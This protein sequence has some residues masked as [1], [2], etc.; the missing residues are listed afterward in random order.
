MFFKST[1]VLNSVKQILY[2]GFTW[3]IALVFLVAGIQKLTDPEA[4]VVLIDSYGLV[5]DS[6]LWPLAI[7]LPLLEIVCAIALVFRKQWAVIA[8]GGLT[9][10]FIAVLSYGI[11]MGLDVDCGCFG[12]GDPEYK[13][14][15]SLHS[16]LYKDLVLLVGI[17][18]LL[19]FN[20]SKVTA[21]KWFIINALRRSVFRKSVNVNSR[22]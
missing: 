4:F 11:W 20:K 6:F 7:L 22:A 16:A 21:S 3:I 13:A 10:M 12:T 5:W 8:L 17:G 19:V 15:S 14:Y 1:M 18:Y 9:L 2:S